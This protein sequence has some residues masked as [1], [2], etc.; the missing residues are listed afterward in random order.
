M[1]YD[2]RMSTTMR[3]RVLQWEGVYYDERACATMGGHAH[4]KVE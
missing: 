1:C 3:G 4:T 2:E